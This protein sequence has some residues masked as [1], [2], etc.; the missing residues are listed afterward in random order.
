MYLSIEK[1]MRRGISYIAK[2]FSKANNKYMQSYYNKKQCI[3]NIYLDRNNPYGW[4]ISQYLPYGEI[5]WLNLKEI[6][7]LDVK[8]IGEKRFKSI[9]IGG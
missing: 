8:S 3:Y 6:D 7:K 1:G 5:K 2:R 9:Y 4:A